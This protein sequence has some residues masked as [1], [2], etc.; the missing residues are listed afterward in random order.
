M[1][2]RLM[3][4]AAI[5]ALVVLIPLPAYAYIDP[6]M[7]SMVTTAILGAF[8]ALAFTVRSNYNSQKFRPV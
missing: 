5:F 4:L 2:K 6:G 8:A 7:G 3:R 1:F